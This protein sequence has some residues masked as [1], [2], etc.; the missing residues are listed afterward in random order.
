MPV[1]S[2]LAWHSNPDS[3]PNRK[4]TD[5]GTPLQGESRGISWPLASKARRWVLRV[6]YGSPLPHKAPVGGYHQCMRLCL[7]MDFIPFQ[8]RILHV[9]VGEETGAC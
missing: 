9:R 4:E 8:G 2:D 1:P 5:V 6:S 3:N 7:R